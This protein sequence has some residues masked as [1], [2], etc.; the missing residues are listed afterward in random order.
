MTTK[1]TT[2]AASDSDAPIDYEVAVVGGGAAGLAAAVFTARYGLDT[3]VFDGGKAAIT[4]CAHVENYLG[5]PGGLSPE[6]EDASLAVMRDRFAEPH[7]DDQ[8]THPSL[9]NK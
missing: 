4:Q 9:Q 1:S 5:F 3:A 6:R 2:A 8:V 7:P